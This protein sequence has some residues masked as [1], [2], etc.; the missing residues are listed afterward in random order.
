MQKFGDVFGTRRKRLFSVAGFVAIAVPIVFGTLNALQSLAQS[1]AQNAASITF[2]FD[3][4][5]IKASNPDTLDGFMTIP[6]RGAVSDRFTERNVTLINLIRAAYG[7][8]L[9]AADNRILG[10][11]NWLNSE[12]Y[13]VDAKI[14]SSMVDELKKL[15]P[16]QR[17][18]AQ[19]HM[20]QALL[21]DRF[22]LATHRETKDLPIYM[23][24]AMKNGPKLQEA[25]PGETTS[26]SYTEPERT[27]SITGQA[28]PIASLVQVLSVFL[29]RPVLDKS[30]LPGKYDFKL[31]WEPDDSQTF[32]GGAPNDRP[33]SQPD[34]NAS[35]IFT[36]IQEQLGLKLVS[37]K[38]PVEI[39]VIDHVERPSAN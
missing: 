33:V 36:A 39:V 27:A 1:Q 13:D 30:G 14:D 11:P 15:S 25:K 22:R 5:S 19:Q 3:V 8:P 24:V 23:L 21:A 32:S 18:L 12:K 9:G 7:I 17:T 10:G 31:E 20:L 26:I 37:G 6:G 38:G 2:E 16:D 35:S 4:A 34:S 28:R 29:G